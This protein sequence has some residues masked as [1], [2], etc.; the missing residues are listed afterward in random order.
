[1]SVRTTRITLERDTVMV[2]RRTSAE[3]FWCPLCAAEVDAVALDG[4]ALAEILTE[5][6]A[7]GPIADRELHV[8]DR[9]G[10]PTRVC[11]PSLLRRFETQLN[12]AKETL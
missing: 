3:R 10:E 1:M 6:A 2:V 12:I 11:L 8:I 7:H 4:N 9:L 5:A